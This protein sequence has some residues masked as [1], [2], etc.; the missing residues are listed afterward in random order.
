M[1]NVKKKSKSHAILWM[2][3]ISEEVENELNDT[4]NFP[5]SACNFI[6]FSSEIVL[7]NA[8]IF[9]KKSRCKISR[10]IREFNCETLHTFICFHITHLLES[11]FM[12]C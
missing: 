8:F 9:L 5:T 6:F 12:V 7:L 1:L 3:K 4:N 2:D 10:F 11:L